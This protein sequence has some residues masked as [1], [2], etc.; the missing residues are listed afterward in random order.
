MVG[1]CRA[2]HRQS[3]TTTRYPLTPTVRM[4]FTQD[5]L[6]Q[7]DRQTHRHT[8]IQHMHCTTY[9]CGHTG[10]HAHPH[11]RS[12][13]QLHI[14]TYIYTSVRTYVHMY[15]YAVYCTCCLHQHR[16]QRTSTTAL[17]QKS[18]S[19]CIKASLSAFSM[20]VGNC[21]CLTMLHSK[22]AAEKSAASTPL[23]PSNTA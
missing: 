16:T 3:H 15:T 13:I 21:L 22:L 7:T 1:K 8:I 9:R 17:V 2:V 18:V 10:T 4:W 19:V 20:S 14:R 11:P 23:W 12:H 6:R 5:T